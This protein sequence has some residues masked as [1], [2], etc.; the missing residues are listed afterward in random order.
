MNIKS[1]PVVKRLFQY[2]KLLEQM[3]AVDSDVIEPQID[4]IL[5]SKEEGQTVVFDQ[6][7]YVLLL[8]IN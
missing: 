7:K 2:R 6:E 4:A 5:Q 8:G 3:D 1:H